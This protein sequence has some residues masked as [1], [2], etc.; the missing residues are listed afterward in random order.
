MQ[1][2]YPSGTTNRLQA[3]VV[4]LSDGSAITAGTVYLYLRARTGD[5][6]GYWWDGANETWS[7]TEVPAGPASYIGGAVWELL[8]AEPTAWIGNVTYTL[9]W[10][11]STGLSKPD[12][13]VAY[14]MGAAYDGTITTTAAPGAV[15]VCNFALGILGGAAG[16]T[17]PWLDTLEGNPADVTSLP[18]MRWCQ[19]LYP[20][21]RDKI[22][23]MW[24]WPEV[25]R[26]AKMGAALA[27][28]S[29]LTVPGWL[30]LYARPSGSLAL[31]GLVGNAVDGNTGE[32]VEYPYLE[33][34]EQIACNIENDDADPSYLFRH[35]VR[36]DDTTTWSEAMFQTVGHL[37][38]VM[39]ARPMGV[40]QD[41]QAYVLN[42][43]KDAYAS[44]R[45]DCQK[46][47]F[48]PS[49]FAQTGSSVELSPGILD[50]NFPQPS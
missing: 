37:L 13:D 40:S 39:L 22:Q 7:D 16:A 46:R 26:F 21:A 29:A 14:P 27:S 9:Y 5:H 31:R 38:A 33:I 47:C 2:F 10:S 3:N 32:W 12:S 28:P 6:A 24:D 45:S 30:Y 1:A 25:M 35:N 17:Y 42:L 11:E 20:R 44:A 23:G 49:R 50:F 18:A 48:V 34:G 8:I 43:F 15:D 36:V 4:A 19:I 41:G